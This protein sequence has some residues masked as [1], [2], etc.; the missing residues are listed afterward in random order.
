MC[1]KQIFNNNSDLSIENP[2][3]LKIACVISDWHNEIT[4]KLFDGAK[5]T[6]IKNGILEKNIAKINVPG[7]FELIFACKNLID[8]NFDAVIAIGCII[9]GETRHFEFV[10]N[11]VIDGIKDLNIISDIPVILCVSTDDNIN[12]SID[13]SGGKYNKGEDSAIA[14]LKMIKFNQ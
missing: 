10:S 9:Q 7:S 13:R 11:A 5:N 14:A 6:L 8:K 1:A 3:K 2:N 4:E 12:Q